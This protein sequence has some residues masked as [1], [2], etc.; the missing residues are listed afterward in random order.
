M[1]ISGRSTLNKFVPALYTPS[2]SITGPQQLDR[3]SNFCSK[4]ISSTPR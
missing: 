4:I 1:S 3:N 2:S